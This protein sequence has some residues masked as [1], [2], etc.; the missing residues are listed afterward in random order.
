MTDPTSLA[1][2]DGYELVRVLEVVRARCTLGPGPD[3]TVLVTVRGAPV[4][5]VGCGVPLC[6]VAAAD[7]GGLRGLE[8]RELIAALA[9][10][11]PVL[12]LDGPLWRFAALASGSL[13][14]RF[15]PLTAGRRVAAAR[16]ALAEAAVGLAAERAA[17][18]ARAQARA[19]LPAWRRCP[20]CSPVGGA[21][22][23][24]VATTDASESAGEPAPV[25]EHY[26]PIVGAPHASDRGSRARC[27]KR[28]PR[29]ATVYRYESDYT[30]LVNGASEDE[31]TLTRLSDD[32]AAVA[33]AEVAARFRASTDTGR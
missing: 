27:V 10:A 6:Y 22:G 1:L 12:A 20:I 30:Y 7:G 31:S 3:E 26:L 5:L 9:G 13:G 21:L 25:A 11:A 17:L 15:G 23:D 29:C 33:L 16:A 18:A 32:E 4:G 2:A 28:C 24:P 8:P 19:G 14:E